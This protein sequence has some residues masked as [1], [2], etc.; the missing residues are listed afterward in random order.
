MAPRSLPYETASSGE[1]ATDEIRRTLERFGAE[2]FGVMHDYQRRSLVVQFKH[3]GVTVHI[4]AS[5]AGYAAAWL[6]AHPYNG[7][8]RRSRVDHER[9]ASRVAA[10]ATYSILRDWIKG[11]ITAIECGIL[12]FEGAF[13]GQI[14]LPSGETA[15]QYA[16]R[17]NL[18][19]AAYEAKP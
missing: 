11:Q 6:K 9:E 7:R 4:E 14:M 18:L 10:L 19:P 13:L 16:A 1:R 2:S 15:L 8:M 3:R 12:S 17:G 5:T